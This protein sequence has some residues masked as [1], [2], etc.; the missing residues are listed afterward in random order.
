[1]SMSDVTLT[2]CGAGSRW[3]AAANPQGTLIGRDPGCDVVID[4]L[5]VSRR[6]ARLFRDPAGQWMLE[7]LH[8]T[9]GLYVNGRRVESCPFGPGDVA[10][11]GPAYLSLGPMPDHLVGMD[12]PAGPKIAVED[13]GTEVLYDKP[14]LEDC[15]TRPCPDQLDRLC[16]RLS[17]LT[18]PAQIYLEV[19]R[20]LARGP[21][22]GAAVFRTCVKGELTTKTL[23][24]LAY[25][26]GG[27]PED[28]QAGRAGGSYPSFRAFRVS[29]RLLDAVRSGGRPLMTK[30]IFSCDTQVTLSLMDELSPRALIGA[31]LG[32]EAD[33]AR[34]LYVD[35]PIDDRTGPQPEE[36][37][38]FVQAAAREVSGAGSRR[39]GDGC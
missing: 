11:I 37:F 31:P 38:A 9:N 8:S 15:R 3:Q 30:S 22:T 24:V 35:V 33:T 10:K 14:R 16:R 36:M 26:F 29:H 7:D 17:A 18:V 4:T 12:L 19:C 2:I 32:M 5:E 1:M 28:T 20:S 21:K 25:H 27:S 23:E 39:R 13:F 34:L 6:H